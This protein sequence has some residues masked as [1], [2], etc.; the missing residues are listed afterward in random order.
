MSSST[1]TLALPSATPHLRAVRSVPSTAERWHSGGAQHPVPAQ[2]QPAQLPTTLP[3]TQSQSQSY[4]QA[5]PAALLTAL[6]AGATVVATLP[7][8]AIP[9]GLLAQYGDQFGAS[10]AAGQPLVG[11]L[12]LLPA[13]APAP[14]ARSVPAQFPAQ[15]QAQFP[16]ARSGQS[17][18]Q[19]SGQP[20]ARGISIDLERRNAW[21][22][23]ELLDLTYL[24]F[25]LLAHLTGHP[26]RV[27]TRD[28]LVS[29]VWGYGH[30]GDGR[31]V[32]VHVAR[33]RRKLGSTYRN[34]IVT[35]RRVGYKYTPAA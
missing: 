23:G 5:V 15:P 29:A 32:D 26:Q 35:V 10:A 13:E 4:P 12:I 22:D 21:V 17:P 34:T 18:A 6:P 27:H 7:Q 9:Q 8:A 11:Y 30:I 28:H 1:A 33:L 24:E 2:A 19:P 25:E 3:L 20:S 16:A 31:T 14:G